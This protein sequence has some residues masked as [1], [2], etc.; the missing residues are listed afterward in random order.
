MISFYFLDIYEGV[1]EGKNFNWWLGEIGRSR[2][3]FDVCVVGGLFCCPK[4][5]IFF[6]MAL[7]C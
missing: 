3:A 4:C 2:C 6:S 1:Y 7:Y 5:C